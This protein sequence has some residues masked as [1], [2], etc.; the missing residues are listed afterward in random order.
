MKKLISYILITLLIIS[1]V[2]LLFKKNNDYIVYIENDTDNYIMSGNGIVYKYIDNK[3][4]IVTNYHIVA[5]SK[6]IYVLSKQN[7]KSMAKLEKYDD[8][9]DIAILSVEGNYGVANLGNCDYDTND[10]VKIKG[11]SINKSGYILSRLEHID[12]PNTYGNSVYDAIK[13]KYNINYGDSG[14]AVLDKNNNVIGL[15]SVMDEETK[16]GYAIPICDA[17]NIVDLLEKNKLNRPNLNAQ[18]TN[19]NSS[20]EGVL[21]S[22]IY[23]NSILHELKLQ[24]NDVITKI[25]NVS[26]ENVSDFRNELYKISNGDNISF[27]Y[28]RNGT[29]YEVSGI[30]K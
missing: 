24:K 26:V 9:T 16:E 22:N 1:S 27:S 14:S 23:D 17:M 20:I 5:N 6:K 13:I 21:V 11:H 15:L 4:F 12:V 2:F 18:F 8:Y 28:Y 30:I 10:K 29:Y 25:N 7:K 3:Y 19:N